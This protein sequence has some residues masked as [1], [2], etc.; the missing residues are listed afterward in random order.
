MMMPLGV[1]GGRKRTSMEEAVRAVTVSGGTSEGAVKGKGER[2]GEGK[3]EGEGRK[4][5]GGEGKEGGREEGGR[6]EGGRE[7]GGREEGEREEGGRE[8]GEREVVGKT[9]NER[10]KKECSMNTIDTVV[11]LT[12]ILKNL[13]MGLRIQGGTVI[14]WNTHIHTLRV[15]KYPH[16]QTL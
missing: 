1:S 7:E 8:E 2:Q 11:S 6:E 14:R 12:P 10:G 13:D 4:G 9:R 5:E 16:S 3:G 15:M